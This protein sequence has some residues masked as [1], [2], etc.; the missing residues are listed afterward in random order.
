MHDGRRC[1]LLLD[2]DEDIAMTSHST[3]ARRIELVAADLAATWIDKSEGDMR[4]FER[5]ILR[6]LRSA[7]A[8]ATERAAKFE[9]VVRIGGVAD[10]T[11]TPEGNFIIE[12]RN[13][14][15]AA[16]MQ[17]ALQEACDALTFLPLPEKEQQD[18]ERGPAGDGCAE[19]W[20]DLT[21]PKAAP[22][23]S[24]SPGTSDGAATRK[25]AEPGAAPMI[26]EL[27][28]KL[29]RDF[30]YWTD[31]FEKAVREATLEEVCRELEEMKTANGTYRAY[32]QAQGAT[33]HVAIQTEKMEMLDEAI[34]RIRSLKDE[35]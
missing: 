10:W 34:A 4:E 6:A 14:G 22:G 8:A 13:A 28:H 18:K 31:E 30:P 23:L 29:A 35:P 5:A 12:F 2:V 1:C 32:C 11:I 19:P 9:V 33:A 3:E 16:A 26:D 24:H 15:Q 17:H 25:G 20:F 7:D 27:R 21:K